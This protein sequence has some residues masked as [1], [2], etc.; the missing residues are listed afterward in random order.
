MKNL[1]Q[2]N[3]SSAL[4]IVRNLKI[5]YGNSWD[6]INA[7]SAARMVTQNRFK[8]GLDIANIRLLL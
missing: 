8:T 1:S 2:T 6:A 4:E 3:Y 5:K 7:E